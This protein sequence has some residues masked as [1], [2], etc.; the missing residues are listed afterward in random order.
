VICVASPVLHDIVTAA[1]SLALCCQV[2]LNIYCLVCVES[3][4]HYLLDSQKMNSK[5]SKHT[6][7]GWLIVALQVLL[8]QLEALNADITVLS[9]DTDAERRK[10]AASSRE[11]ADLKD[12]LQQVAWSLFAW[13][14]L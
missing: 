9:A 6:L 8:P 1:T 10:Q 4:S 12:K 13:L 14:P 3:P 5:D 7:I 11:V 2:L